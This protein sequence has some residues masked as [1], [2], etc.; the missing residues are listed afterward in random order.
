MACHNFGGHAD[1]GHA[2]GGHNIGGHAVGGHKI[3]GHAVGGHKVG[4][5]AVGGHRVG[6]HRVE[7]IVGKQSI[8]L[9]RSRLCIYFTVSSI[10][11]ACCMGIKIHSFTY[12]LLPPGLIYPYVSYVQSNL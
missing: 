3:G 1:G 5:H 10:A 11:L 2:V 4:G 6:G 7:P 12:Y 9:R 8:I